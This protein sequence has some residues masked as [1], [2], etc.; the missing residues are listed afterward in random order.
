MTRVDAWPRGRLVC[1]RG[2]HSATR[3]LFQR[4]P[5]GATSAGWR[6]ECRLAQRVPRRPGARS[7]PSAAGSLAGGLRRRGRAANE[8]GQ[9]RFGEFAQESLVDLRAR[10]GG[11]SGRVRGFE[12]SEAPERSGLSVPPLKIALPF[13]AGGPRAGT[14]GFG[15]LCE[16]LGRPPP[17]PST[18][19]PIRATPGLMS[20]CDVQGAMPK[21]R[22]LSL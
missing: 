19:G 4:V 21:R 14:S 15:V 12:W 18:Q 6:N 1:A 9:V 20:L 17:S 11:G 22:V 7:A 13:A 2:T 5:A 8:C 3:H 10:L 16:F